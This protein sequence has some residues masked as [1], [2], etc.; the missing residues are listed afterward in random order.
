MGISRN[1]YNNWL[2]DPDKKSVMDYIHSYLLGMLATSALT[3]EIR[4]ISSMYLQKTMGKV[5]Q[6]QP[7]TVKHEVAVNE[8]DIRK[9]LDALKQNNIIEAEYE[10]NE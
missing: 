5:E 1:T 10:E 9:Q 4:E 2:V 3:G 6:Q 7:I 8:D